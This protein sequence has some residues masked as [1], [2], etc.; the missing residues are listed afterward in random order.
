MIVV[1]R[2]MML[3]GSLECGEASPLWIV[4]FFPWQTSRAQTA[5]VKKSKR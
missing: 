5:V 3:L 1:E 2:E 4:W